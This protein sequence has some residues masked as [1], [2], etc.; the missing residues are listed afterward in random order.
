VPVGDEP[1]DLLRS[2]DQLLPRTTIPGVWAALDAPRAR[3]ADLVWE[4]STGID[5]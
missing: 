4:G 5:G 1:A 2:A 3:V